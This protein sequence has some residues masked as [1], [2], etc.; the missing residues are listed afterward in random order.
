MGRKTCCKEIW[1]ICWTGMIHN[2]CQFGQE[3]REAK[4]RVR[5]LERISSRTS[6]VATVPVAVIVELK[7]H[8]LCSKY[9]PSL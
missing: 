4:R 1:I 9:P 7:Y 8:N 3:C 2:E 5:R 6:R